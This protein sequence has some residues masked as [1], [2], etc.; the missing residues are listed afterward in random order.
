MFP[1]KW[2]CLPIYES[3]TC[4]SICLFQILEAPSL[5]LP[6]R[7][8]PHLP[9]F[10]VSDHKIGFDP[11][12]CFSRETFNWNSLDGWVLLV[13]F[14]H[15]FQEFHLKTSERAM[16]HIA[17]ESTFTAL[18]GNFSRYFHH[19]DKVFSTYLKCDEHL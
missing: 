4:W 18:N 3:M 16:Q 8:T 5:L 17:A 14:G 12:N 10:Q 1:M 19:S 11:V 9:E 15:C 7:S 6:K 2:C 13:E